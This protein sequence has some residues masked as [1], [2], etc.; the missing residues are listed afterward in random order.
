MAKPNA[1]C[2]HRDKGPWE[3]GSYARS[4]A[5]DDQMRAIE[6]VLAVCSPRSDWLGSR[7]AASSFLE[8]FVQHVDVAGDVLVA[9]LDI[10]R[11]VED[12]C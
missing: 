11:H 9:A 10:A 3:A 7:L 12:G 6:I 8:E 2:A 4:N 5:I 1:I